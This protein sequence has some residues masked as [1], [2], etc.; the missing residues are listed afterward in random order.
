MPSSPV[1]AVIVSAL[2][3]A[4]CG[5]HPDG[6]PLRLPCDAA[7]AADGPWY[8]TAAPSEH[9]N[10]SRRTHTFAA[11]ATVSAPAGPPAMAA[12][13][14]LPGLYNMVTREAGAVFALGG[15]FGHIGSDGAPYVVRIDA[16]T[17]RPRWRTRLPEISA[18]D[19]NYP[20]ALGV[21]RNGDL[22]A[23]Y[24]RHLA[25]LDPDSGAVRAHVRLPVNQPAADVAYNGFA[26]LA[27]GRIVTKSIHRRPGC[28]APDFKAFLR[29]ETEGMAAS[30]LALVNPDT[31]AVEQS[32]VAPEH[33]RFRVTVTALDGA[34]YIYVPGEERIRR[35][36]YAEGRL[37]LDT[38]WSA[39][40][41]QPGQ[42][43][44]TAVAA[45][46]DWIVIQTNGIP[47]TAPLSIVAVSQR[48]ATRQHRIDPFRDSAIDGSFIPSLPTVDE[49]HRRIYTFDAF[50]GQLAALDFDSDRG[51]G[52]A[53]K[54]RQRSF[55]FSALAG[56]P[57]ARVLV[58]TDMSGLL[59]RL[60]FDHL[61]LGL[62][63]WLMRQGQRPPLE[64]VVWRDAATGTELARSGTVAAVAGSVPTPGHDGWLF[65]P[66]LQGRRLLRFTPHPTGAP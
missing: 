9:G 24:G 57:Q 6:P 14:D 50:A 18:A 66:D 39:A 41:R 62:R 43:P 30:T 29:C 42:T 58:S 49:V 27:D 4:A 33:L 40:Y 61:N 20:G 60:A 1:A 5:A 35:Y 21:H 47:A 10:D 11:C 32:L 36:R 52:I 12:A 2:A 8:P 23:V 16:A 34:E 44:G 19:W 15:S 38:G 64:A 7:P 59:P 22:Y 17:M 28:S 51:L 3:L 65:V 25:R 45:L 13:D 48:D 54:A 55:A 46:G 37:A 53:W 31:L 26:L 63:L 56:P